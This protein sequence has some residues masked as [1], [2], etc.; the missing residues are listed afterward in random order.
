M[1][2]G[3]SFEKDLCMTLGLIKKELTRTADRLTNIDQT[4]ERLRKTIEEKM[5]KEDS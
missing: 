5:G 1:K 4:L 3:E 2:N